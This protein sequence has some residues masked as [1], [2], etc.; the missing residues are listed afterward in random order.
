MFKFLKNKLSYP[1]IAILI[2]VVISIFVI[3]SLNKIALSNDKIILTKLDFPGTR[4]AETDDLIGA[5]KIKTE[6]NDTEL[7]IVDFSKEI[8]IPELP[9]LPEIPLTEEDK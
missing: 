4:W 6:T 9:P 8:I 5:S 1:I 3:L 2:F 7:K